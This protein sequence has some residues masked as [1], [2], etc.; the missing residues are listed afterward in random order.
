MTIRDA[1][2]GD[3]PRIV[4]MGQHFLRA[5][6]Y[7]DQITEN[8][9]QFGK[10]A[11]TCIDSPDGVVLLAEGRGG[12]VVGMIGLLIFAHHLSGQRTAGE[13]CWWVEPTARG[14]GVQLLKAAEAWAV[15]HH[16]ETL[17]M[18]A[19]TAQVA[20]IYERY[21]YRLSEVAYLKVLSA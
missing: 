3:V 13:I 5:S 20:T 19:P 14:T 12:D 7:A 8:P 15:A 17:Q 6:S 16:A 1:V 10:M 21:G 11:T 4:E 18:V 9:T 2:I